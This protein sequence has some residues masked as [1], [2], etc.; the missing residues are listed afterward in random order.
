M[1]NF[2]ITESNAVEAFNRLIS[3]G[4]DP[5]GVLMGIGE[6]ATEFTKQ[7]FVE[8][9]DPYGT[10][11]EPNADA[12]L[13]NVLHGSQKNFTK[14]GN[15]SARGELVLAGKKPLIGDSK[16][17]STQFHSTV[18]GESVSVTSIAVQAAMQ[19]FGGTKAEFPHLWGDIPAR[20]YFP[21]PERGLPEELSQDI[22]G[23]LR[24]ALQNAVDGS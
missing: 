18:L 10:P 20:S 9:A 23:V 5:S 15:V 24:I 11:W 8:S 16:T 1:F 13:R 21:D 19:H 17:L 6:V 2:E 4:E 3:L 12:T 7:R 14:K 22:L